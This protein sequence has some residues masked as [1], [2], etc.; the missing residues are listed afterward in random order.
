MNRLAAEKNIPIVESL[1]QNQQQSQKDAF[2]QWLTKLENHNYTDSTIYR[3]IRA[4]EMAEE[5]LSCK[6]ERPI[7]S[8]TAYEAFNKC[9]QTIKS[10]P[11]YAEVNQVHGHGD[12]SAALSLYS[13]FLVEQT[14]ITL[15]WW[16]AAEEYHPG[17]SKENWIELLNNPAIFTESA[18]T[19]IAE[20]YA[21]GGEATCAQLATQYQKTYN[22]YLMTS[23]HLAERVVKTTGCP[24]VK[25]EKNAQNA[26]WWPVLYVGRAVQSDR[27]HWAYI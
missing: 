13:K 19:M 1:V 17:I 8:I 27:V 16:P 11:N 15:A 24:V 22:Y 21:F 2:R 6:L 5:W 14:S 4:L 9:N 25:E 18:L 7:F 23:V 26:M 3:Y 10:L 20:F 12:L